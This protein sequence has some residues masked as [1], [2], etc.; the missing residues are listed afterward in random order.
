MEVMK[1]KNVP[2]S[3]DALDLVAARFRVL[4]EPMRLRLLRELFAGERNVGELVEATRSTQANVSKHL[5]LLAQAGLIYRRKEGLNAYYGI[6][7]ESVF[8]LCNLVCVGLEKEFAL[9]A[10]L[11]ANRPVRNIVGH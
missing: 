6:K 3:D 9:Q 7:D 10:R 2:L 4:G 11:V 8:R 1:T 5:N